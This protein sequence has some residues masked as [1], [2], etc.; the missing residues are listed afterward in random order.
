MGLTV[1][2]AIHTRGFSDGQTDDANYK[3]MVIVSASTSG[4]LTLL[5]ILT[6][7]FRTYLRHKENFH[8]NQLDVTSTSEATA[9]TVQL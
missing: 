9:H 1:R 5:T 4:V 8:M 6:V 3:S 7:K 2:R